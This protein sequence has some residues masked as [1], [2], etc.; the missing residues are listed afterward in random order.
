MYIQKEVYFGSG[1]CGELDYKEAIELLQGCM[2]CIE[3]SQYTIESVLAVFYDIG[4]NDDQIEHL[5]FEYLLD[6]EE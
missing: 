6:I 3:D 2:R 4:F 1:S 5:G